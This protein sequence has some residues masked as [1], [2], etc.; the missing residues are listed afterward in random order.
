MSRGRFVRLK[1]IRLMPGQ[2]CRGSRFAVPFGQ[3]GNAL[4]LGDALQ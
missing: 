3:T 1:L 2:S 4:A